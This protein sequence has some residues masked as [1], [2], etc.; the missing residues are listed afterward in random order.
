[1]PEETPVTKEPVVETYSSSNAPAQDSL[2]FG[3]SIRAWIVVMLVFTL[4]VTV[5]MNPILGYLIS[6][7][8]FFEVKEPFYSAVVISLGYYF[9]QNSKKT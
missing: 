2:I 5:I 9:G 6:G 7:D 3:V 4:C 8:L 1:M